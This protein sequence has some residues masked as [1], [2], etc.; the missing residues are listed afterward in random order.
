MSEPKP[1][2]LALWDVALRPFQFVKRLLIYPLMELQLL[3]C[4]P[5][6]ALISAEVSSSVME[7]FNDY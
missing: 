3:R 4:D 2:A 7:S 5:D 1:F 6:M